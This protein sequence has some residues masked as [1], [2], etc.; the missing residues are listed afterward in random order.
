MLSLHFIEPPLCGYSLGAASNEWGVRPG[1]GS[2]KVHPHC[3][4]FSLLLSHLLPS[5]FST[6]KAA[7]SPALVQLPTGSCIVSA[8]RGGWKKQWLHR[9]RSHLPHVNTDVSEGTDHDLQLCRLD[10]MVLQAIYC[11]PLVY[12]TFV[13]HL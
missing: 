7:S 4:C 5:S 11:Q 8:E 6:G 1:L 13:W 12:T 9:H 10:S 3:C 2:C